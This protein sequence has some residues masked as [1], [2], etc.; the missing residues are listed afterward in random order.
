MIPIVLCGGSGSRLWPL[1]RTQY[2]KQF[3]KVIGNHSLLQETIMRL[4]DGEIDVSRGYLVT[5]QEYRFL[6][7]E[8]LREIEVENYQLIL[9]PHAKGTAAA[10]AIA[11]L[12]AHKTNPNEILL[13]MSSDH[14]VHSPKLFANAIYDAKKAANAGAIITLGV[15]PTSPEVG[16]GYIQ[17]HKI[18]E[19]LYSVT[20]FIEKPNL[21]AAQNF[22][23]DDAYFWNSGIFIFRA[24]VML[25]QLRTFAPDILSVCEQSISQVKYDQDFIWLSD[26]LFESCRTDSIDYAV[27]EKT[28]LTQMVELKGGW[29]DVGSWLAIWEESAKDHS[30][31]V[32]Y[33][34]VILQD[35]KDS[36]VHAENR[37]IGLVD[38]NDLVVVETADALLIT[39]KESSQKVKLLTEQL[40][41]HQR[42]ERDFHNL[43]YRPWGSY[44]SINS[45]DNY[46]VKRLLV[47]IGH[48]ISLQYHR[49]RSEHWVVVAGVARVRLGD[50]YLT[51]I[52]NQSI[53]IPVGFVHALENIGNVDLEVIEVQTGS[54]LGEDDIVRLEDKY[55][56]V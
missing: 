37:L 18:D 3:L 2:P 11:T 5:N 12:E 41:V 48:S 14:V 42:K 23:A 25:S 19:N 47:G 39:K 43:I 9:E 4:P 27:M 31:N 40:R 53:F 15:K 17:S 38:V 52:E 32:I 56:R 30:G 36:Y 24:D 1:S 13:V 20:S 35:V 16:Y 49:H 54:Y 34:D 21:Q 7:A 6:V 29:N 10:I 22:L 26:D 45:G 51:L 46:Q 55:G 50:D 28:N 8:Q 33:G 44:E